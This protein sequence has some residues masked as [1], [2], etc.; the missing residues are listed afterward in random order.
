[1][2]NKNSIL[3]LKLSTCLLLKMFKN[4]TQSALCE[5]CIWNIIR[6]VTAVATTLYTAII[7][8]YLFDYS[9]CQTKWST[10][11]SLTPCLPLTLNT[12]LRLPATTDRPNDIV[13]RHTTQCSSNNTDFDQ[14]IWL[15]FILH[16]E[17]WAE[18]LPDALAITQGVQSKEHIKFASRKANKLVVTELMKVSY[19]IQRIGIY[20]KRWPSYLF[21]SQ[22]LSPCLILYTCH[23]QIICFPVGVCTLDIKTRHLESSTKCLELEW[24]DHR[25]DLNKHS[26]HNL[27][28]KTI[29]IWCFFPTTQTKLQISMFERNFRWIAIT[30]CFRT[31]SSKTKR[32]SYSRSPA[33]FSLKT[34]QGYQASCWLC[35]MVQV[36]AV[37]YNLVSCNYGKQTAAWRQFH[38]DCVAS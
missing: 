26:I 19:I 35:V 4:S 13:A 22:H 27:L 1:M 37:L 10:K 33:R 15:G 9:F 30:C 5:W 7:N 6:Y 2:P 3:L 8:S 34:R 12:R 18:R 21:K 16:H 31:T 23:P 29:S 38:E 11:T 36:Y 32:D 25:I 28:N 17:Y 14:E 24:D 20:S